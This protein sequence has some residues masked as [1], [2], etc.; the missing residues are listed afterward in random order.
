M[1][2][3]NFLIKSVQKFRYVFKAQSAIPQMKKK[4]EASNGLIVSRKSKFENKR[5]LLPIIETSHYKFIQL[6]LIAKALQLRGAKVYVLVCDQSLSICEIRSVQRPGTEI[7]WNCKFNRNKLLPIFGLDT[8]S[9]RDFITDISDLKAI[10]LVQTIEKDFPSL[11]SC[12]EDSV[13]RHYYGNLELDTAKLESI[14]KKHLITAIKTWVAAER[15]H[16]LYDI[17][18]VL[19]Y[20]VAYSEFAP[21]YFY[22][23][24]KNVSFKIIS[25]TQFD[26]NAQIFNWPELY[27]SDERFVKYVRARG[28]I[29]LAKHEQQL[30]FEFIN[31]RKNGNDPVL[32][33]LGIAKKKQ[34]NLSSFGIK[35]EKTKKNIFLFSNVYWDVGMSD[36][37]SIFSSISEWVFHSIRLLAGHEDVHLYVRC[38]PA[39]KLGFVNGQKGIRELILD[40]FPV[41]PS[42]LTII[43]SDN[44]VSSYDLY[45]YIDLGLVYNG[46]IGLEMLLEGIPIIS[47]GKAPYSF[48]KS[49]SNATTISEY[50]SFISN[51]ASLKKIDKNEV[52][53]FAYFYLLKT[54]IPW[55]L[56]EKS[57]PADLFTPFVF[58]SVKDLMPDGDV[59]INHICECL[60]DETLSPENWN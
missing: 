40:E 11:A 37:N 8:I 60:V 33:E 36:V 38:H 4:L 7:C 53:L 47:A 12:I 26:G 29:S 50:D 13:I 19:G 27:H 48:L 3:N 32:T 57:Y 51:Q 52:E 20:M 34:G 25:S 21:Y 14:R 24:H 18:L 54:S 41:L 35:I 49:V 58:N 55:T 23:K 42:N 16:S 17:N 15:I 22:F 44:K 1:K 30:L 2:S 46:T 10:S 56:T 45:P 31:K 59:Y 9:L 6:L 39:E 43:S 28:G 5:I